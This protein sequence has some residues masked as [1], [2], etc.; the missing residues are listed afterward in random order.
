MRDSPL[1]TGGRAPGLRDHVTGQMSLATPERMAGLPGREASRRDYRALLTFDPSGE[2]FDRIVEQLGSWLREKNLDVEARESAHVADPERH[3]TLV[4]NQTAAG[5]SLRLKLRENTRQ[6]VWT[7]ELTAHVPFQ[8]KG[9]PS[10]G[11]LTLLVSNSQQRSAAV[12]RLATYL[13]DVLDV[14]DGAMPLLSQAQLV[15]TGGVEDL[16]AAVRD[17]QRHG[18]LFVAGSSGDLDL[19]AWADRVRLWTRDI[20]GTAQA[21]VLDPA[22]TL[23]FNTRV[24]RSHR[25]EP[26]TIRTFLPA[27]DTDW[28]PDGRRHRILGTQRLGQRSDRELR[29]FIAAIARGHAAIR[30]APSVVNRVARNLER[31]SDDLVLESIFAD[32]QPT[33]GLQAPPEPTAEPSQQVRLDAPPPEASRAVDAAADADVGIADP[34]AANLETPADVPSV[35]GLRD[36]EIGTEQ[37]RASGQSAA[38]DEVTATDEAPAAAVDPALD[39]EAAASAGDAA[40]VSALRAIVSQQSKLLGLVAGLL[41]LPEVDAATLPGA[42]AAV[43]ARGAQAATEAAEEAAAKARTEADQARRVAEVARVDR[44]RIH[45]EMA[46]RQARIAALEDQVDFYR[47]LFEDEEIYRVL[48]EDERARAED[49]SRWLRNQLRQH[50]DPDT[51]ASQVPEESI[52]VYPDSFEDLL[53]RAAEL[54]AAGVVLTGDLSITRDLD[55]VDGNGKLVRAAWESLLVLTDYVSARQAGDHDGSIEMYLKDTPSGYR[56]MSPKKHATGESGP[57]MAQYGHLRV[58]PVPTDVDQDGAV[59]MAAHFK[60]GS[61]GMVSP[62]LH[63]HDDYVRTGKIYVGYIGPH[64]RTVTTN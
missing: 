35:A 18:L 61:L 41:D 1:R 30:P 48:A 37:N 56:P 33:A 24:G 62:R 5:R 63:Y 28:A 12:P 14:H 55:D 44:A 10:E 23:E 2:A 49:E 39:P 58:H 34:D 52:T 36:S 43:A 46:A 27:A 31:L 19:S 47:E 8:H 26:W 53:G 22:A 38:E 15:N 29:G 50:G 13:L 4:H 45:D 16:L 54:E 6:G 40:E 21:A 17:D 60:L 59:C 11:W 3:L 32:P 20:R 7:T 51:A 25:V 57:T 42:V 9:R 64:L